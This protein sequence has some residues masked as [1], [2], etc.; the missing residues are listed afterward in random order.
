MTQQCTEAECAYIAG[1]SR[2]VFQLIKKLSGKRTVNPGLG[3]KD[4]S[5]EMI[6]DFEE[7]R[8][9]WFQ[10]GRSLFG[11]GTPVTSENTIQEDD[12]F[13]EE[14]EPEV[15]MDE[16]RAAI[17]KLKN[18]KSAGLDGVTAEMLKAGGETVVKALKVIIDDIWYSGVWPE[19]WTL[20]ELVAIPKVPGTQD[21]AKY[22]TISLISHAGKILMEI[23]RSRL[24]HYLN[25]VIGEEQFGFMSGKGTT[26]AIM[27]LRN[28]IEKTL[29]RQEKIVDNVRRLCQSV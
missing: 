23:M 21:C 5:G 27:T 24:A 18:N 13:P 15:M 6:Y 14:Y 10:H 7:I 16:I 4:E 29:K 1:N 28:I 17:K 3:I 8:K 9:R 22:M 12:I 11:R 25:P 2:K 26:D 20:S 19:E